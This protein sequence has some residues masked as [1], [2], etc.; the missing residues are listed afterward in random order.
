MQALTRNEPRIGGVLGVISGTFHI[1]AGLSLVAAAAAAEWL[2]ST[3]TVLVVEGLLAAV[4]IPFVLRL[5]RAMPKDMR[6]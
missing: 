6:V 2:A 5:L 1:A 4:A 3:R